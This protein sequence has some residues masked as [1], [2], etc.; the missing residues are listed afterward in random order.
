MTERENILMDKLN[1]DLQTAKAELESL[2]E[3]LTSGTLS[4][5]DTLKVILVKTKAKIESINNQIAELNKK[6]WEYQRAKYSD[7]RD[8]S[9]TC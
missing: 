8:G 4:N 3:I 2:N 6:S 9:Y 1:S 7:R 5:L